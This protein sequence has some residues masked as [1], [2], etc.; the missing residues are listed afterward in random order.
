MELELFIDNFTIAKKN[1]KRFKGSGDTFTIAKKPCKIQG[2]GYPRGGP[3]SF[4]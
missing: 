1:L 4:Y 3:M 2:S